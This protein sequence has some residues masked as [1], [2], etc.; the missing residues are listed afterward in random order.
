M[1]LYLYL[2]SRALKFYI[3]F[4]ARIFLLVSL[5]ATIASAVV[6][7]IYQHT[8]RDIS[9][10][11]VPIGLYSLVALTVTLLFLFGRGARWQ[12]QL[13]GRNPQDSVGAL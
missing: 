8:D 6:V 10:K 4:L 9:D 12:A 3:L 13:D 7:N 1:K 2:L 5:I 11:A